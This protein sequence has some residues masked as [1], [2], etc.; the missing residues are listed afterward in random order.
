MAKEKIAGV[1][2][3]FNEKT[4]HVYFGRSRDL[5]AI[6]RTVKSKLR[7]DKFHNKSLQD[8]FNEYGTDCYTFDKHIPEKDESCLDLLLWL[9]KEA[10]GKDEVLHNKIDVIEKKS[11]VVDRYGIDKLTEYE[12]GFINLFLEKKDSIDL[13]ELIKII[14]E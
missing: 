10:L 4:K 6:L 5:D 12:K 3:V 2:E 8:E 14:N 13:D 11:G 1:F 9:E 7:K